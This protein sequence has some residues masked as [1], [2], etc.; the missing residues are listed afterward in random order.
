M[1]ICVILSN[2]YEDS[3]FTVV[4]DVFKRAG[5]NVDVY[6]LSG[7]PTRSSHGLFLTELK[8]LK[9]LKK[10]DY[11]LLFLPGGK[12]NFDNLNGNETVQELSRYFL[13]EKKLSA[14][15]A[16]PA[17]FGNIGLLK[18]KKYTCY[19]GFN[20]DEFEGTYLNQYCVKDGNLY[21]GRS[22]AASLEFALMIVKDLCGEEIVSDLKEK[23]V[24]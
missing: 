5:M 3:E 18:G 1:N 21:T 12:E 7:N 6:S 9:D 2:G 15:C 14:I 22:M 13:Q 11:D 10:E 4:Y 8:D 17:V 16:S 20:Q 19:P 24:Y 23:I